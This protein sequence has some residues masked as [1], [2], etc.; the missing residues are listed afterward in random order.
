ME[1]R[2]KSGRETSSFRLRTDPGQLQNITINH[3]Q[4]ILQQ[5]VHGR[6]PQTHQLRTSRYLSPAGGP[7]WCSGVSRQPQLPGPQ[8]CNIRG[9]RDEHHIIQG[10]LPGWAQARSLRDLGVQATGPGASSGRGSAFNKLHPRCTV[11]IAR[12]QKSRES[13]PT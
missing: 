6:N 8:V 4:R 1:D 5:S 10:G 13:L 2:G 3:D 7:K 12:P 11:S 9:P